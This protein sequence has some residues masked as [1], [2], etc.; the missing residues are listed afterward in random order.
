MFYYVLVET[1]GGPQL[2]VDAGMPVDSALIRQYVNEVL[3]DIIALTLGQREG[4]R[5]PPAPA[6]TQDT[7]IQQVN[8][9]TQSSM[10]EHT[11]LLFLK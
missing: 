4:L 2:V 10:H 11:Q 8:G 5:E 9:F 7:P 1:A 3:A 6:S